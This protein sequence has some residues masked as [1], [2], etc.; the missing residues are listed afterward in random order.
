L[1]TVWKMYMNQA[2]TMSGRPA[3]A[4]PVAWRM[5]LRTV[6]LPASVPPRT[7]RKPLAMP[8]TT[9]APAMPATPSPKLE[10]MSLTLIPPSLKMT[11]MM[12]AARPITKNWLAISG[13]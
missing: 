6:A 3:R 9:A 4:L 8:T 11:P 7:R 13:M 1:K 2:V 5:V 12:P 10:A